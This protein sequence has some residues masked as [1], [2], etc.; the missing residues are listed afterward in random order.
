M[1]NL[2][3]SPISSQSYG[4]LNKAGLLESFRSSIKALGLGVVLSLMACGTTL[5]ASEGY[6][7]VKI[8]QIKKESVKD[9]D[10]VNK[11][12][13]IK[14][15]NPKGNS[16]SDGTGYYEDED[17]PCDELDLSEPGACVEV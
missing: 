11:G 4:R 6:K 1:S 17:I 2:E 8:Q 7:P 14:P 3:R 10:K 15:D 9:I 13:D 16:S 12:K 5:R